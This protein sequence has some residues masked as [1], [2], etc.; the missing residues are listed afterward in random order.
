MIFLSFIIW[1]K[2]EEEQIRQ[3][4]VT[5]AINPAN[6][7]RGKAQNNKFFFNEKQIVKLVSEHNYDE[8]I[9]FCQSIQYHLVL[10]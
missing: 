9:I 10:N 8:I 2:E 6:L 1:L 3:Q 4:F 5:S 7:V